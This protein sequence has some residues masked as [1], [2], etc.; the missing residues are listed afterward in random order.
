M[1]QLLEITHEDIGQLTDLQLTDLLRR[2]LHLEASHN[3]IAAHSIAVSL[4]ITVS[5]GGE[6]GRVQWTGEP[7]STDYIPHRLTMFQCKATKM[8]PTECAKELCREGSEQLKPRV[9][10]VLDAG[11][12]YVL[13]TTQALNQQQMTER[14]TKMR[15]AIS[16]A[17]KP[18][19][20]TTDLYIYDANRI[21]AWTNRY[22]PAIIAV[23][24][25]CRRP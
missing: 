9:E 12:S 3:N 10:E 22:I 11:G 19:A 8:G 17:G 7:T 6:D 1:T 5:D 2:L 21:Q 4:N 16:T 15:E 23:C 14:F 13:F 18:Y 25:W 20:A 24:L